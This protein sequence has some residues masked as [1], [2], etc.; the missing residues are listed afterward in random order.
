MSSKYNTR[1]LVLETFSFFSLKDGHLVS[2]IA[3]SVR[4]V[5]FCVG[6]IRSLFSGFFL[7]FSLFRPVL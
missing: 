7:L 2:K 1:G 6:N 5:S 4:L 3:V